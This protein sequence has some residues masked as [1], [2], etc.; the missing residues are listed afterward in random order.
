MRRMQAL[1]GLAMEKRLCW[2]SLG[3]AGAL[4]VAFVLDLILG[5][6]FGLKSVSPVVDIVAIICCALLGYLAWD[7]LQDVR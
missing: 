7:A 4:L 3:I 6:P 1:K 5:F 2:V